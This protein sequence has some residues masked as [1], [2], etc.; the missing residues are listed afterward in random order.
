MVI[1]EGK[2]YKEINIAFKLTYGKKNPPKSQTIFSLLVYWE[3]NYHV[4]ICMERT[5]HRPPETLIHRTCRNE[6]FTLIIISK[7]FF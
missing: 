1:A 6:N 4:K 2:S 7:N 3:H 5:I